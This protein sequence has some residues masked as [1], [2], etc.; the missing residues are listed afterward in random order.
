MFYVC[1]HK[2]YFMKPLLWMSFC[3][4][5][6]TC[7]AQKKLSMKDAVLGLSSHLAINNLVQPHWQK[8]TSN[9]IYGL[10]NQDYL[11]RYNAET[12]FTDTVFT[13]AD[14][15]T[16]T[17]ENFKKIPSI[18]WISE[19]Q[20]YVRKGNTFYKS[21]STDDNPELNFEKIELPEG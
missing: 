1:P 5:T 2:K 17:S 20:F 6:G 15:N 21:H 11:L 19:K 13:L 10:K 9:F 18:Q 14:I 7:L 8:N 16:S 4:L 12:G 3:L